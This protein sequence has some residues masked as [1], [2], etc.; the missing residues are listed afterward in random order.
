MRPVD[1][2]RADRPPARADR[3]VHG[4]RGRRRRRELRPRPRPAAL[5]QGRRPQRRRQRRSTTAAW[6][7]TCRRCAAC[8]STRRP[9][10]VRAEGGATWGD[11]DRETQLHGLAVPGGVV[12]TTGIA[13]LTLHGGVGHLRRKHGLSIDS[14]LSVD[15]VT[16][17]GQLSTGERNRERGSVLGGARRGQQLRRRHLLRVPGAPGRPDG[18]RRRASSIRTSRRRT[19]LA[20]LARRNGRRPDELSSLALCWSVPAAEPFPPELHGQPIVLVAGVYCG[21]GRGRRAR[22]AAAARARAS[23]SSTSAAHGPGS[24]CRAAST[25]CSRRASCATGSPAR[26]P[27]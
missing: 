18:R 14:L 22:R 3:A 25:R 16:A 6:S 19:L 7:S 5:G 9:R 2:E 27:S 1:L 17:D 15:I 4:R 26:S 13:G 20:G 23:R 8:T 10:S 11:V 12:S 24:G 21:L